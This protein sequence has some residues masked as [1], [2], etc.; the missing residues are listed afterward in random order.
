MK[1]HEYQAKE[2]L[3]RYGVPLPRGKVVKTAGEA[4]EAA[5]QIGGRV[6]I[7]AQ[8]HGGG[9]GK[10]GGIKVAETPEEAAKI[11]GDLLGTRLATHQTGPEGLPVNTVLVEEA[12]QAEKELYLGM[13]IDTSTQALVM[14]AS[15]AGGVEI[16][17]IATR[18]PQRILKQYVNLVTG[19]LPYQTR[20]LAYSMNLPAESVR[21]AT[22]IMTGIYRLLT[23][24]DCSLVEINPLV[25][26]K[27]GKLL[28]LDCKVNFDDNALPRHQDMAQ[29]RDSSQEDPL[30][31]KASEIGVNYVKIGGNVGCLVNGA[32]LAMATMDM[33]KLAGG[34]PANFLDVGGSASEEQVANALR[35]LLADARVRSAWINVFGGILRCDVV[36]RA[37]E[38]VLKER[39]VKV[40]FIV[41]MNG[42]NLKEAMQI[43]K[44]SALNITFEADLFRA[45]EMAVAMA[46]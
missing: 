36:A 41:R 7:K 22:E 39:E 40:P 20:I 6:V 46:K 43:L 35:I 44:E 37:L 23:E 17:D 27:D 26:T 45:A 9:R 24:K 3:A 28:A 5:Q 11:A 30:E 10:A 15:E 32:G 13:L 38:Q 4:R 8:I 12:I 42:T 31:A 33:I 2:L 19:F 25:I 16:E 1:I 29:L 18:S 21:T 34:E 14:I